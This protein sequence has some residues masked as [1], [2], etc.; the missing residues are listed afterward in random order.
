[1]PKT[2][3]KK[4]E[5]QKLIFESLQK[6]RKAKPATPQINYVSLNENINRVHNK[7]RIAI[8]KE[9]IVNLNLKNYLPLLSEDQSE[10]RGGRNPG[11]SAASG[12]EEIIKGLKKAKQMIGDNEVGK[13]I[14]NSIVRLSN[15]MSVI[16]TYVGSGQSQR[17]VDDEWLYGQ[18]NDIP[19]PA[20]EAAEE[21]DE[22]ALD[23]MQKSFL[24]GME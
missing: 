16:G 6:G 5:L 10:W 15:T 14:A 1:M 7:I 11:S 21:G 24:K 22:A 20:V 17:K 4:K 3:I 2:I 12:I 18:L 23:R 8:V 9:G 19:Y 13:M